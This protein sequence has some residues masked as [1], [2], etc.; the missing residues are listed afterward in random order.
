MEETKPEIRH[1]HFEKITNG[2][3]HKFIASNEW[4]ENKS[5]DRNNNL[6]FIPYPYMHTSARYN[7][8]SV[9]DA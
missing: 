7:S 5:N 8:F 1:H 2:K 4:S 9:S 6:N 3:E